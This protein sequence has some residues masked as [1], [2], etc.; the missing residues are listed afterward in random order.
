[1]PLAICHGRYGGEPVMG[2]IGM[3]KRQQHTDFT[4]IRATLVC[5][6][7][8]YIVLHKWLLQ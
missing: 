1:M 6:V 3:R 4:R 5:S 8:R 7:S 2:A